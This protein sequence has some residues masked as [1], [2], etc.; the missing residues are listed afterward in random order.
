MWLDDS[1]PTAG[2]ADGNRHLIGGRLAQLYPVDDSRVWDLDI[3][4]GYQFGRDFGQDVQAGFATAILGHTWKKAP[5]KPRLSGLVYYGSGD[6][7]PT[8]DENNTFCTL[9]PLGHAYWAISDNLSGQNLLDFCAQAE[10]KPTDK[11]ALVSAWHSFRLASDGDVLYNVAGAPIGAAGNGRDVGQALDL[12]G[13]YAMNA[14]VD[15]QMGY[16]WFWYGEYIDRTTPRNDCTQF[17]VQTSF[18]Y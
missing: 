9:F 18:R 16:S 13:Y 4:G 2:R 11:T 1:E 5:W 7:D 10:V 8:D 17:Y 6:K 15:L 3:E 14:N 12:Y